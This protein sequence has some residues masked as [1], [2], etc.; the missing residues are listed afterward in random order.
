MGAVP[1]WTVGG[2]GDDGRHGLGSVSSPVAVAVAAAV[3]HRVRPFLAIVEGPRLGRTVFPENR[4]IGLD[5]GPLHGYRALV[6]RG[7]PQS[8]GLGV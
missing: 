2:G 4:R 6:R 7:L 1:A 5:Q 8:W 3:G